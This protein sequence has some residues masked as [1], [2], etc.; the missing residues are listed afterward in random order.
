MQLFLSNPYVA[1]SL[2]KH[3]TSATRT[4]TFLTAL[5]LLIVVSGQTLGGREGLLWGVAV[6]LTIN[7]LIY[8]YPDLRLKLLFSGEVL[9]GTDPWG[10]LNKLRELAQRARIPIPVV[11]VLPSASPQAMAMGRSPRSAQIL[12]TQ[13]LIDL[14]E[15]DELHAVLAYLV[16][17]IKR[18]DIVGLTVAAA[19]M[20]F[21][22][23][24]LGI[25]DSGLRILLGAKDSDQSVQAH[26]FSS[27]F[28]PFIGF[29]LRIEVGRHSY[30]RADHMASEL[31]TNPGALAKA[32]W[33]LH[34]YSLTEPFHPPIATAHLWIVSPLNRNNWAQKFQVQPSVDKRIRNI[35]GYFPV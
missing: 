26:F 5:M 30:F 3:M 33:K 22:L 34:S 15:P 31:C 12:L 21:T 7:S 2:K 28:A 10:V 17:K 8:L 6:A 27:I 9:E 20:D 29:L 25:L 11:Q 16:A 18:Q 1:I 23:S 35:V 19:F 4:W 24:L 32:L 13:G 14:L